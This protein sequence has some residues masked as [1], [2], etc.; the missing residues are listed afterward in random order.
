MLAAWIE[1]G[2]GATERAHIETHLAGCDDCRLLIAQTLSTRDAVGNV[3]PAV[4]Y[5]PDRVVAPPRR[6]WIGWGAA[7]LATA[8]ALV[9]AVQVQPAWWPGGR[10]VADQRLADLVDA[11]GQERTVEARLTGGFR[12]GHLRAPVRSGGSLAPSDNWTLYAAAGKIREAA[13]QDATAANLHAL[14]LAHLLL[15]NHDAAIE[16]FEDAI[17]EDPQAALFRSDLAAA[18]LARATQLDRPDD[19]PRA[20]SAAEKALAAN[21]QLLEARFNKAL[22]LESLFL[23]E[24]ARRAWEDYLAYDSASPWAEEARRH[25]AALQ[26]GDV[27]PA[28]NS[29]PP[30]TDTTVEAGLDWMLRHGLPGW[31]DAILASDT[32]HAAEAQSTLTTYAASIEQQSGDSFARALLLGPSTPAFAGAVQQFARGLAALDADRLSTAEPE[33]RAACPHLIGGL[34]AL[35]HVEVGML[36]ALHRDDASAERR[37]VLARESGRGPYLEARSAALTGYRAIFRGDYGAAANAYRQA[38]ERADAGK[39]LVQAGLMSALV[40]DIFE[41]TGL[42]VDS[43]KWRHRALNLSATTGSRRLRFITWMTTGHGLSRSDN[44]E[45]ARAFL[46]SRQM[47]ADA[48]STI[49]RLPAL[50]SQARAA[51]GAGD[52]EA[53]GEALDVADGIV[54]SSD[55]FR[56]E[57]LAADVAVLRA[58]LAFA[59]HDLPASTRAMDDALGRMGPERTAQRAYALLERARIHA[60]AANHIVAEADLHE[61]IRLLG[62]RGIDGPQPLPVEESQRAFQATASLVS[63]RPDLRGPRGLAMVEN[64]RQLLAG[65]PAESPISIDR[66]QTA[67][68][69]VP[70]NAMAV[71]FLFGEQSLLTWVLSSQ[72]IQFVER[73]IDRR[74]ISRQIAVLAV[75]LARTPGREDLWRATLASLYQALF[76]DLPGLAG[77]TEIVVVPDGPLGRVPFSALVDPSSGQFL[78]ERAVVR[79][80]PNL[81]FALAEAPPPVREARILSIG[82]PALVDAVRNGFPVLPQAQHEAVAVAAMYARSSALLGE[83]ATKARVLS[84]LA[85]VDVI[86]FA[87]HGIR[88]TSS[89]PPRLLLAGAA[90]DVDSAISVN[91]LRHRLNGTRVVLAACETASSE[92][93]DRS[94]GRADFAGAFLRAGARSVVATLWKVDDAVSEEFFVEVHRGLASGRPAAVAV[95]NA[96]RKCRH[97]ATCQRDPATWVGTTVYGLE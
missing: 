41:T 89:A 70:S 94:L 73:P 72:G 71:V 52:L 5:G 13:E 49:R 64:I 23:E 75:Q 76:G 78:F 16:A 12:H 18:Y 28:N 26:R 11:V 79:V 29:P 2:V 77:A 36:D 96:Q 40:S 81:A 14:G 34:S 80:A 88:A 60:A 4:P 86:H 6:S 57:R 17:A 51:L 50:L 65:R 27:A 74:A 93:A 8:A 24:Q 68:V 87:G 47:A 10:G 83:Y 46:T 48:Q 25:L 44:Y 61:A 33:L 32:T 82:A 58:S 19:F 53:A 35:C 56:A 55:D 21:A 95:A 92:M 97:S 22:A 43:W 7:A 90:S 59:R 31:A 20:L 45:A 39:Y 84:E 54:K 3:G 30:I 67:A 91:D 63:A 85:N 66:I 62:A 69:T 42:A 38:Y 15:G 1:Q 9:M 37:A